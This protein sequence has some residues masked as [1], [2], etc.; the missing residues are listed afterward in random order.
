[1]LVVVFFIWFRLIF[2]LKD[3][4]LQQLTVSL[5]RYG[6][7]TESEMFTFDSLCAKYEILIHV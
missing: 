2:G 3:L 1:M 5:L 6:S 4:S 7:M